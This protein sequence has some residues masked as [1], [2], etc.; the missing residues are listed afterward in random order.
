MN[1]DTEEQAELAAAVSVMTC[2]DC[3]DA[4]AFPH[5]GFTSGCIGCCARAAARG[6]HFD[7]VRRAG[8]QDRPYR[9]LL[10]QFGLTHEQVREAWRIDALQKTSTTEGNP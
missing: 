1:T 5:H 3:D 8:M 6:H 4:T 7:R 2:K 10:E 9:T